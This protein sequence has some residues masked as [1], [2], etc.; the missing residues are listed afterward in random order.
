MMTT[1]TDVDMQV[2]VN[3]GVVIDYAQSTFLEKYVGRVW[4]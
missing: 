3:N 2:D 1:T 4:F